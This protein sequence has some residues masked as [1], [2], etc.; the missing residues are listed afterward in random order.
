VLAGAGQVH[1]TINGI[2]ERAGNAALEEF[3]MLLRTRHT[4]LGVACSID[5]RQIMRTSRL[6]SRLTGIEVPPNKAI[7]GSNAFAHESGIH[8]DGVLKDS[9][10]YEIMSPASVGV[11]SNSIVLGKHSGRH[12]LR[13]ALDEIGVSVDGNALNTVF[14]QFK[15][16]AGTKKSVTTSDLENLMAAYSSGAARSGGE[17]LQRR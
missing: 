4:D 7:V 5:T 17:A 3:V 14:A 11:Q 16:L 12:A 8:Q 10:T 9:S 15:E 13:R 1:C 2:G 6:V